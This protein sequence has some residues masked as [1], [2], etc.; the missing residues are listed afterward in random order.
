VQFFKFLSNNASWLA[1]GVL[2]TFVSSFGQTFF[3]SIFGGQIRT[4][5]G[6][7]HAAWGGIYSLG[8]TASA[9]VMI[10]SGVLSDFF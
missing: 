5:F 2:L 4:E 1:A 3:I 9:I 7:S 10:W 8:T 6:L